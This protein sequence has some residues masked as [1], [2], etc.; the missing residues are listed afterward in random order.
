MNKPNI[1]FT[2]DWHLFH[3]YS[4]ELDQ[5]PFRDLNHMHEVLVN[6]YNSTVPKDGV[7][8]FLGDVGMTR[9]NP[10][11]KEIITELNGTK[12]LILGNHDDGRTKMS[13]L[14]FH[15]VMNAGMLVIAKQIVTMTHCPLRGVYR[16]DVT[17]MKG[18]KTGENWHGETRHNVFSLP[19]FGQFHLHGHIH[20]PN[21]GKSVKILGKQMDI[22]VVANQYRPVSISVIESWI[23]RH[24]RDSEKQ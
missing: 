22:G 10:Q 15:V 19:D 21:H 7:C 17:G 20:S 11:I 2:S 3:D 9:N 6:N 16:E 1:F 18:A 13:K 12:V 4:I 5:R 14:G 24:G 8:Y 23:A